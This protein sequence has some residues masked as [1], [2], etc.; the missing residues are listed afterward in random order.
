[1]LGKF[2]TCFVS[3]I[4]FF[5]SFEASAEIGDI[6]KKYDENGNISEVTIERAGGKVET[7]KFTVEE[8]I[9]GWVEI[10][11]AAL[12]AHIR[13]GKSDVPV[14]FANGSEL[15]NFAREKDIQLNKTVADPLL[16]AYVGNLKSIYAKE[17]ARTLECRLK[18]PERGRPQSET[19]VKV[20][21]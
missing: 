14:S 3:A 7:V 13:S 1:M 20:K 8:A 18:L 12:S 2:S 6:L 9:A 15:T 4:C 17:F 19:G 21:K 10:H 11:L 5:I 16:K